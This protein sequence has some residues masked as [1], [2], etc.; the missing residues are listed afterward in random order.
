MTK[1]EI[2]N[3]FNIALIVHKISKDFSAAIGKNAKIVKVM[4]QVTNQLIY[5]ITFET[6]Q[7]TQITYRAVLEQDTNLKVVPVETAAPVITPA[8][9]PV[10]G[11]DKVVA[12]GKDNGIID[13][14]NQRAIQIIVDGY[15]DLLGANY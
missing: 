14:S 5:I 8:P 13:L 2:D 1:D 11:G 15:P 9:A 7:K 10:P 12:S 6:L 4:H 3:D